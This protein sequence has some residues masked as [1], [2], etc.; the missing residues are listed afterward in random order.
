MQR[1][2]HSKTTLLQ[3]MLSNREGLRVAVI[4]K[5]MS[6]INATTLPNPALT[7]VHTP[8]P[9]AHAERGHRRIGI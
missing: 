2:G 9:R 3:H 1:N 6:E 8:V 4:V 5:D 7:K